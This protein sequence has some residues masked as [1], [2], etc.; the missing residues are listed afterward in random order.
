MVIPT[1]Q[2]YCRITE[3]VCAMTLQSKCLKMKTIVS[4]LATWL[5]GL[6]VYLTFAKHTHTHREWEG[7]GRGERLQEKLLNIF[8]REHYTILY[9]LESFVVPNNF[10]HEAN[11]ATEEPCQLR[12]WWSLLLIIGDRLQ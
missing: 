4:L 2:G 7:R 3:L 6:F 5:I 11:T 1:S 8:K 10:L 9:H 12:S